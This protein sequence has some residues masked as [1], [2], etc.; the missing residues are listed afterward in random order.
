MNEELEKRNNF[1][2]GIVLTLA[3]IVV[4][5]VSYVFYTENT[6]LFRQPNRC[7]YNGWAYADKEIYDSADGCNVCF[8]HNGET[9]CTEKV[10]TEEETSYCDD[11]TI[12]P[13]T[14]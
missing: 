5:L 12:C 4:G 11:G 6:T 10:C 2:L 3:T 9:V 8:C 14:E 7:E 1:L 13:V